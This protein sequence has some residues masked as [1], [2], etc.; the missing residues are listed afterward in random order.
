MTTNNSN[1]KVCQPNSVSVLVPVPSS[2]E[3]IS[4]LPNPTTSKALASKRQFLAVL[5]LIEQ[6]PPNWDTGTQW[7]D[8]GTT[9][10][11]CQPAGVRMPT[12]LT[13]AAAT[14]VVPTSRNSW[15]GP[16]PF[17]PQSQYAHQQLQHPNPSNRMRRA[18]AGND[19]S[20][21]NAREA[22]LQSWMQEMR[23]L[24]QSVSRAEA[25]HQLASL[26][27]SRAAAARASLRAAEVEALVLEVQGAEHAA[28]Q[29]ERDI[30]ATGEL[31]SGLAQ[32]AELGA[33][34]EYNQLM[35]EA[36]NLADQVD[37]MLLAGE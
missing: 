11:A 5:D 16:P 20:S 29:A 19:A 31:V 12:G 15:M 28:R 10:N 24:S 13:G 26:A 7:P 33:A 8:Q 2:Q 9:N 34:R 14:V 17:R 23:D 22:E 21:I 6:E 35:L 3:Q 32:A 30:R 37:E 27:A 18:S 25:S 36:R 4:T 1:S